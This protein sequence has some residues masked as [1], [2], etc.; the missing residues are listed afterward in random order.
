MDGPSAAAQKV[1]R[2]ER[3][4]GKEKK[5]KKRLKG[6]KK[7]QKQLRNSEV[8][9]EVKEILYRKGESADGDETGS[10]SPD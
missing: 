8:M 3:A 5:K 4:E 10:N 7:V 1:V 9:R 6:A 2:M